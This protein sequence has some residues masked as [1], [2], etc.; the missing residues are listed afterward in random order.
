[1][2][3]KRIFEQVSRLVTLLSMGDAARQRGAYNHRGLS[4]PADQH[5]EVSTVSEGKVSDEQ[6]G[7]LVYQLSEP[8]DDNLRGDVGKSTE[9][10]VEKSLTRH[11]G[12]DLSVSFDLSSATVYNITTQL[13]NNETIASNTDLIVTEFEDSASQGLLSLFDNRQLMTTLCAHQR[14]VH[15]KFQQGTPQK[16]RH[17]VD[18]IMNSSGFLPDD[19]LIDVVSMIN[20]A[21]QWLIQQE[22]SDLWNLNTGTAVVDNSNE[23]L[24]VSHKPDCGTVQ[25]LKITVQDYISLNRDEV[26]S[27]TAEELLRVHSR[28]SC[29]NWFSVFNQGKCA[30][31]QILTHNLGGNLSAGIT[32]NNMSI[33][34]FIRSDT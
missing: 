31:L 32:P 33:I 6:P 1:M 21:T 26:T 28:L 13:F 16:G 34:S 27:P 22:C 12:E 3:Q 10:V 20:S 18:E 29:L 4:K 11:V 24:L 25:P 23:G 14:G 9:T 2:K 30:L 7:L 5:A 8:S 19:T 15:E 17:P